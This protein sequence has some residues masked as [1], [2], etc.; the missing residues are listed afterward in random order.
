MCRSIRWAMHSVR[1]CTLSTE[2]RLTSL[3]A[4]SMHTYFAFRSGFA[5]SMMSFMTTPVNNAVETPAGPQEN[6]LLF[7]TTFC[8]FLLL[9]AQTRVTGYVTFSYSS[10]SCRKVIFRG[11]ATRLMDVQYQDI[12]FKERNIP[13]N[14]ELP[15]KTLCILYIRHCAMVSHI[16]QLWAS[17]E[18]LVEQVR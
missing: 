12:I 13:F 10:S 17:Q 11:L 5:R 4:P 9:P 3:S 1:H 8:S 7:L 14:R 15:I 18:T 6:P 16:E 2:M